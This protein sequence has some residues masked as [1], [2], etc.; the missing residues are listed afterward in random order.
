[1]ALNPLL[2]NPQDPTKE[3]SEADKTDPFSGGTNLASLDPSQLLLGMEYARARGDASTAYETNFPKYEERLKPF[4]YHAPKRDIFDLAS[5][6]GAGI[7]ASQQ[8]GGTNPYVGIGVGFNTFSQRL[9]KEQADNLKSAQQMGMQAASLALQSEQQAKDYLNQMGIKLIDMANKK[10]DFI[11][12]EYDEVDPETGEIEVKSDTFPN[13]PAYKAQI[14]D[15]M[16][17]KNGREMKL[18]DNQINIE[19]PN[20]GKK[21]LIAYESVDAAGKEFATKAKAAGAVI[22]QVNE[23]FI[24]AERVKQAGGEFGPFSDATLYARELID[25]LGFGDLLDAPGAIAPQKAL[26]QLSM[27]FVLSIISQ[28]KGAISEKEMDL[29][30]NASPT[31]GSTEKGYMMQLRLLERIARRDKDFY[32]DYL[33]KKSQLIEQEVSGQKMEVELEKFANG[34]RDNNPLLT[35]E[36]E[37]VLRKAADQAAQEAKGEGAFVPSAFQKLFDDR[38]RELTGYKVVTSQAEYDSLEDGEKYIED[39][40]VFTKK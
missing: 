18:A 14:M 23:A 38:K 20:R 10:T 1:M 34:W 6:L 37:A 31:L 26:R 22:D 15:L 36:D 35:R 12:I 28:T 11:R 30:I 8:Q 17:N 32:N 7:L 40:L 2:L 4:A 21:D 25:S 13:T 19:G 33:D 5:D 39:G 24:L 29:F 16:E 3:L 27:G 9:K